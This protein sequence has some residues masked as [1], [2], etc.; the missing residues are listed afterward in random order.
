MAEQAVVE[1]YQVMRLP[2]GVSYEQ[3]ALIEPAAVAIN[4]VQRGGV[5]VGDSVLVTGA[6]PIGALS[7]LAARAAG[8]SQV[9]LSEPNDRR[10]AR[11]D[12]LGADARFD[13]TSTDL[14]AE[15][16]ERTDGRGVDVAIECSGK[17]PGLRAC[18]E[19]TRTRGSVAQVGLHV[20]DASINAW[21]LTEREIS[22]VGVFG[23]SVPDFSRVAAQVDSGA[24]PVERVVTS[25]I[26]LEDV[27][28]KGFEPLVDPAG[29]EIKVLVAAT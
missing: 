15:I 9:F 5:E 25:T 20:K 4:A 8:A 1:E 11:A 12:Q 14:C 3:A 17:N 24:L 26:S 16:R 21:D 7:V 13:P 23:F 28:S 6:G 29:S 22:L 18:L 2:D 27:V 19:A 10:A